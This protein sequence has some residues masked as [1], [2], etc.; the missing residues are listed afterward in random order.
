MAESTVVAW[1][2]WPVATKLQSKD[3]R[4]QRSRADISLLTFSTPLP[5]SVTLFFIWKTEMS[6][7]SC[8]VCVDLALMSSM[9]R[10]K[11]QRQM[12]LGLATC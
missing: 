2:G 12:R 8:V 6:E 3:Q 9:D 1:I 4:H 10:W 5:P 7:L 11:T